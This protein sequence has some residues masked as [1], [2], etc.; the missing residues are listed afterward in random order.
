MEDISGSTAW[1]V[2]VD[3][4]CG[5]KWHI[6]VVV[7]GVK[8][9]DRVSV[10]ILREGGDV[11]G[12]IVGISV[13]I[14]FWRYGQTLIPKYGKSWNWSFKGRGEKFGQGNCGKNVLEIN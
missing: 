14:W 11:F 3:A 6:V 5:A 10:G 4:T 9:V 8:L 7:C 12:K 13:H 1:K 2:R